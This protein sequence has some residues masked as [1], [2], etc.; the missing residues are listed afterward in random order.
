M[1]E[2]RGES[3]SAGRHLRSSIIDPR[4]QAG[5]PRSSIFHLRLILFQSQP[6]KR[7]VLLHLF[8]KAPVDHLLRFYLLGARVGA[9]DL[10]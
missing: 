9:G 4:P 5:H 8:E 1:I 6:V 2:D 3:P 7:P 10:I